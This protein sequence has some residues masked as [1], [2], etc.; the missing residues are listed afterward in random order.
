ASADNDFQTEK[1]QPKFEFS[2]Q[3]FDYQRNAWNCRK[4]N[5]LCFVKVFGGPVNF[6]NGR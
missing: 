5:I 4:S 2:Q 3:F 1:P 6:A